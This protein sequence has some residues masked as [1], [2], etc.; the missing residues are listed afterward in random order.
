MYADFLN[1]LTGW[2]PEWVSEWYFWVPLIGVLLALIGLL[3]FLRSRG[4]ED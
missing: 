3:L 4:Q 2:I 1:T